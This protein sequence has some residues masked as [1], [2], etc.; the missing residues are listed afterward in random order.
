MNIKRSRRSGW[1]AYLMLAPSLVIFA[2][3]AFWPFYQ[4]IHDSL[5]KKKLNGIN[6]TY[7]GASQL[8]K[9][10]TSSEFGQGVRISALFLVYTVP[11]GLI[12]GVIMAVAVHRK[13]AGV[14]IFQTIFSSTIASSVAVSSVIFLTLVNPKIGYFKDV[15]WLSLEH[16]DSALLAVSLSSV[17]QNLG[18]T[19]VIVLAGLQAISEDLI[20]ASLIDGYST[21]RRFFRIIVPLLSPTLMFLTVVLAIHAFQA[22]AP[23]EV[24]TGGGPA[25]TTESLLF[26]ITKLQGPTDRATGAA[27]SLGLFG[28]T[29]VVSG[30]QY[31]LLNRRVQYGN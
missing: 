14:R 24:L 18:L 27:F 26:K 12:L 19:F 17:W 2:I 20:E 31:Q 13:M 28:I 23:M 22:Y 25:G 30:L 16:S 7:V 6:E 11:L 9:N 1:I 15:R 10:L 8:T 5:Y 3:F 29:V 4:L 21:L